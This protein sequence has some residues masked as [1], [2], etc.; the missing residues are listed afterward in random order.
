[1][2]SAAVAPAPISAGAEGAV[3]VETL[4]VAVVEMSAE[5]VEISAAVAAETPVVVEG[6]TSRISLTPFSGRP[7]PPFGASTR[8][9][10]GKPAR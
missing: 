6:A 2:T 5:A 4:V 8:P 1:V 9:T 7:C 10:A 3:V